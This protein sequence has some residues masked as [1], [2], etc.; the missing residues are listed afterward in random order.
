MRVIIKNYGYE[1]ISTTRIRAQDHQGSAYQ[2]SE[3]QGLVGGIRKLSTVLDGC[4]ISSLA[5]VGL[6]MHLETLIQKTQQT[7][8]VNKQFCKSSAP[9]DVVIP[10]SW[11]LS[12][13]QRNFIDSMVDKKAK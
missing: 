7:R 2:Q 11:G 3:T 1:I 13:L 5:H 8:K 4:C 9:R 10:E 6:T 12:E